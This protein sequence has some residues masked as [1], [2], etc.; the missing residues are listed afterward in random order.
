MMSPPTALFKPGE[1]G[2]RGTVHGAPDAAR[3]LQQRII[4][5]LLASFE[6][7]RLD[8]Q[9]DTRRAHF[10]W[11][12][13][14]SAPGNERAFWNHV[15]LHLEHDL[16]DGG[17]L[18]DQEVEIRPSWGRGTGERMEIQVVATD[19]SL[20]RART[21]LQVKGDGDGRSASVKANDFPARETLPRNRTRGLDIVA[22]YWLE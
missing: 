8:L 19:P 12:A 17:M 18:L 11:E 20:G 16:H 21:I 13:K 7:L 6:R 4:H 1:A 2:N 14:A 9:D 22:W 5:L 10:L 3:L 15:R